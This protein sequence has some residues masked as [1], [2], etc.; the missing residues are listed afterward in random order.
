M[1]DGVAGKS[2]AA[3]VIWPLLVSLGVAVAVPDLGGCTEGEP[4]EGVQEGAG[5][6][7]GS[8]V[9]GLRGRSIVMVGSG[10]EGGVATERPASVE[11]AVVPIEAGSARFD[12]ARYVRSDPD[13]SFQVRLPP[14]EY[15]IVP[16]EKAVDPEG[17]ARSRR[18][19][20]LT[21][22]EQNVVVG[23]GSF[24]QVDVVQKGE[25]P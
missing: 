8:G 4:A 5:P 3:A 7:G 20:P 25:A 22:V 17:Y 6:G 24:T 19:S 23:A 21:V 10:A 9:S 12:A 14:G 2:C 11:F 16:K 18:R 15:R 1:S 13:G